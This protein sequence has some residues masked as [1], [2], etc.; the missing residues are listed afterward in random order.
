[1]MLH[2]TR[3]KLIINYRIINTTSWL[4]VTVLMGEMKAESFLVDNLTLLCHVPL[5]LT[6]WEEINIK[7]FC[8]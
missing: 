2:C 4:Y 8:V 7:K 5:T 3:S 6:R 1:M